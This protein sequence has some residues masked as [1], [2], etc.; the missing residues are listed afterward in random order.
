[1][2]NFNRDN[3]AWCITDGSA[4][5]IS[6]VKGLAQAMNLEFTFKEVKVKFPWK[7]RKAFTSFGR[8]EKSF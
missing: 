5:M 4:G 2:N 1:M 8:D 6:Q 3:S 7:E